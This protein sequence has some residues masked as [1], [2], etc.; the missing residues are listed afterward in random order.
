MIIPPE[1]TEIDEMWMHEALK[2]A[3]KAADLGEVP[4][5]AVA[6]YQGEII[7][8]GH[9]RKESDQ[10]PIAHAEILAL[11]QAAQHLGSW[12]LIDVTLYCTLEPC[13]M[14]G[15]AMMQARLPRLVYGA[16]DL[17]FGADGSIVSIMEPQADQEKQFNHFVSIRR[18]VL[19]NESISMLQHF[20]RTIRQNAKR[21]KAEQSSDTPPTT[22]TP[23]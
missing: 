11:Q 6:V 4:I 10:D 13:P 14:C 21:R 8:R 19:A 22:S 12:R 20:F 18:G 17:K 9:N 15:G 1:Q 2:E 3:Q 23:L 7:G 5:G 16:P